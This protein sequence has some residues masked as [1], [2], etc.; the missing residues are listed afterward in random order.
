[1]TGANEETP[2]FRL[3]PYAG[4][5]RHTVESVLAA[6]PSLEAMTALRATMAYHIATAGG[7]VGEGRGGAGG[8][9]GSLVG[10]DSTPVV[11]SFLLQTQQGDVLQL[12][13]DWALRSEKDLACYAPSGTGCLVALAP[14]RAYAS[15]ND[16]ARHKVADALVKTRRTSL[17]HRQVPAEVCALV[18]GPMIFR[19]YRRRSTTSTCILGLPPAQLKGT[20]CPIEPRYHHLERTRNHARR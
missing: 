11:P 16:Q 1:M 18:T 19:L 20:A 15:T 6:R 10:V 2:P 8:F 3:I 12:Q 17:R 9:D 14:Y 7:C 4:N 13:V 5:N